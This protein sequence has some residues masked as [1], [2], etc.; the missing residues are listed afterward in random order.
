MALYTRYTNSTVR[1]PIADLL[2][3][4]TSD[5]DGDLITLEAVGA[6]TNGATISILGDSIWYYPSAT[7]PNRNTTDYFDYRI[8]DGFDGGS[9][10]NKIRISIGGVDPAS[11]PPLLQD[12]R[13]MADRVIVRLTGVPNCSYHVERAPA[14]AGA[15]TVWSDL[16]P[17]TSDSSGKAEFTDLSPSAGRGFYRAVWLR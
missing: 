13:V 12:V 10:T 11:Q 9:A 14:L 17:I 4:Y 7:D 5:L 8:N 16:G 2:T 3:N 15:A 1:I 6:G